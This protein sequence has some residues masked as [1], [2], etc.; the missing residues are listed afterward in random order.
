MKFSIIT[1]S[2]NQGKYIKD[3]IESILNQ[4]YA[5][6]E[7]IIVDG[8]STDNTL[9]VLKSYPHLKW[10]SEKDKGPSDAINKGFRMSSGEILSWINADDYYEVNILSDLNKVFSESKTEFV[11]GNLTFVDENKKIIKIDKTKEYS[12][13]HF[14]NISSDITR[15]PSTFF[16]KKL[17]Y[18][19]GGLDEDLKLVFDYEL[20]VRFLYK[21]KPYYLDKNLAYYRDHDE[22]LTRLNFRRQAKEIFK[23]SRRNKGKLFSPINKSNLRKYLFPNSVYGIRSYLKR[24]LK[25]YK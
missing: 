22:T 5:D 14:I 8:G 21:T 12:L 16:T 4:N 7:H 3:T 6:F 11:Y 9:N 25:K 17:Y 19:V 18:E 13:D 23:V 2:F 1:P 24:I 20:F 10:I 15:Q